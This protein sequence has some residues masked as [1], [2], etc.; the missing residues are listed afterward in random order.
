MVYRIVGAMPL[1]PRVRTYGP[2]F[3]TR[4]AAEEELETYK[5]MARQFEK[6]RGSHKSQREIYPRASLRFRV[7]TQHAVEVVGI[8]D[9]WRK[10]S[11]MHFPDKKAEYI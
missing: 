8:P 10:D 5:S 3:C 11:P 6:P 1:E 2:M 9:S 7:T 4:E